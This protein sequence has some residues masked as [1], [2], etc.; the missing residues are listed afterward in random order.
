MNP[1]RPATTVAVVRDGASGPEVLMVRREPSARFMGGA[2]VFPGGVVDEVDRSPRAAALVAGV[3]AAE[4]GW[5]A[6]GL[7]ELVEEVGL[8]LTGEPFVERI[9]HRRDDAVY[10]ELERRGLRFEAS[11]VVPFANWVTPTLM[12]VRFDTRFYAA[13]V[14]AGL[15]VL[16]DE[17]EIDAAVWIEP[18]VALSAAG[19]DM[20]VPFPTIKNLELLS[21]HATAAGLVA[22]LRRL[23][24]IPVV[25]PRMGLRD[26]RLE[27]ALPGDPG[28]DE[29][30]EE[31]A[32]DPAAL[33]AALRARGVPEA[34]G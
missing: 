25:Q 3:A 1:A 24:T 20:V 8:W 21:G 10:R 33:R 19:G 27:V 13:V 30:D 15:E 12:P 17:A 34:A 26:G 22:A 2:W 7:R 28:F 29:I 16:P 5:V 23:E 9:D 18:A 14:P 31:A 32:P 11:G 6:A 4:S